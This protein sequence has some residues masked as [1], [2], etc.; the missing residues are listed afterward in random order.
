MDE[1]LRPYDVVG[2]KKVRLGTDIDERGTGGGGYVVVDNGLKDYTSL[3]TLGVD[4]NNDFEVDFH[5]LSNAYIQQYDDRMEKPPIDIPGSDY[6]KRFITS[7][8]DLELEPNKEKF[9]NKRFFKMDVEGS[10]WDII[11]TMDFTLYEQIC[12][13]IHFFVGKSHLA[14]ECLEHLT[15]HHNIVHVH[16]CSCEP[17]PI[18]IT[19]NKGF[20]SYLP[21]ILE[22]TLL[23]KDVAE[24]APNKTIYP[25]ELDRSGDTR[26]DFDLRIHP[27]LPDE[28]Y[29]A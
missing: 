19:T 6:F 14:K 4:I 16:A 21:G 18:I 15:K 25:T 29:K 7:Q 8:D 26:P 23:R 20:M 28:L 10:E 24:F 17:R 13:E 5:K 11:P 9:G 22:L 2:L 12:I 3:I 27:F 1:L